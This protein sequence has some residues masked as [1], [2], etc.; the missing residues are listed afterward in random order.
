MRLYESRATYSTKV[1]PTLVEKEIQREPSDGGYEAGGHVPG[2]DSYSMP[3]IAASFTRAGVDLILET[4]FADVI[5]VLQ[6]RELRPTPRDPEPP[7]PPGANHVCIWRET[8]Y[9]YGEKTRREQ[10]VASVRGGDNPGDGDGLE[11][12]ELPWIKL[13]EE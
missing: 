10:Q 9:A 11:K 12:E 13:K 5:S 3:G 2:T 8:T 6:R 4:E 1:S 7:R